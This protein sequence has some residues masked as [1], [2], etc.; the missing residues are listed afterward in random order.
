MAQVGGEQRQDRACAQPLHES[1]A[2]EHEH[3]PPLGSREDVHVSIM[4]GGP[5]EAE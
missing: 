5:L 1:R 2:G 4:P 3:E